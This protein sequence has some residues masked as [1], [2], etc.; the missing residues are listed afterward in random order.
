MFKHS[1]VLIY[2]N[3]K[4]YKTTFFINLIGLSCGLACVLMI[5]LWVN[6]ELSFDKYHEKGSRLYQVMHND[7]SEQGIETSK[8][9]PNSLSQSLALD[10]PEVE[11]A[12]VVTP[13]GFFSE[14]TLS[15]NDK[16]VKGLGKFAG[17]DFFKIFSYNLIL[18]NQSNVLKAKNAIV[19]SEVGLKACLVLL[20]V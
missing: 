18:G 3:L 9:T 17:E 8:N 11:Y 14:F 10:I 5:Y 7:K 15:G 19:L 20:I 2:R 4:R 16:Q 6:D 12:T 1:L 13:G